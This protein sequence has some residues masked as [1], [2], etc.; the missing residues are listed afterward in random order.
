V[1]SDDITGVAEFD[2]LADELVADDGARHHARE[3]TPH[4]VQV[5]AANAGVRHA[6]DRVGRVDEVRPRHLGECH[7]AGGLVHHGAH[8]RHR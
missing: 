3:I 7:L 5:G 4:H 6:H 8:R 2:H 1:K